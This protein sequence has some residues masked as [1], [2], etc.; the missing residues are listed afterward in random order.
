MLS[1]ADLIERFEEAKATRAW[2][3]EVYN[4]HAAA[5]RMISSPD[6]LK[7][8]RRIANKLRHIN[9]RL[10]NLTR[11]LRNSGHDLSIDH[12]PIAREYNER[13]DFRRP[14]HQSK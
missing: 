9:R 11:K 12:I 14:T 1:R 2:L 4:A 7:Q 8:R 5:L 13:S 3:L 6:L 10:D